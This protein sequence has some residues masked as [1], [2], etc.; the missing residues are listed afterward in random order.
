MGFTWGMTPV[1][2]CWISAV[3]QW[4]MAVYGWVVGLELHTTRLLLTVLPLLKGSQGDF[5]KAGRVYW[6]AL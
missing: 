4:N 3:N 1:L 2:D 5:T 6:A